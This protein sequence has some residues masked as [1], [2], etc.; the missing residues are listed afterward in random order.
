VVCATRI[1]WGLATR[2]SCVGTTAE[3]RWPPR[4]RKNAWCLPIGKRE[5]SEFMAS[6]AMLRLQRGFSRINLT[7]DKQCYV[8]KRVRK[9]SP[10]TTRHAPEEA[11]GQC[12]SSPTHAPKLRVCR[13]LTWSLLPVFSLPKSPFR[14]HS[15]KFRR[16][17]PS[18]TF[19]EWRNYLAACRDGFRACCY[20]RSPS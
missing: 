8:N 10:G 4:V 11:L 5:R 12:L 3:V 1:C 2:P 16:A 9:V 15:T 17:R 20:G 7:S 19:P 13:A 18:C 6:G 14:C